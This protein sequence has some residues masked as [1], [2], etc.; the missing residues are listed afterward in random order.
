[1][2]FVHAE[3]ERNIR[4]VTGKGLKTNKLYVISYKFRAFERMLFFYPD[5]LAP[6]PLGE[7]RGEAKNG[8]RQLQVR[9]CN[10]FQ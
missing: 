6:S 8:V 1:M 5:D 7:G 9:I 2:T 4:I 3:A 10:Y